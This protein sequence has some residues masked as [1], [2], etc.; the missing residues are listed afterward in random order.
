MRTFIGVAVVAGALMMAQE[1]GAATISLVYQCPD[2]SPGYCVGSNANDSESLVNA[3]LAGEGLQPRPVEELAKFDS[4]DDG[5]EITGHGGWFTVTG[6]D[7]TSG[8]FSFLGDSVA[9]ATYL[10]THFA[11]KAGPG[12]LLYSIED[13]ALPLG[14]A[15]A[16]DVNWSTAGLIVGRGNTPGLS[17]LTFYGTSQPEVPV[18][19]P[20]SMMLLGAGLLGLAATLRRRR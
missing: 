8:K 20:A 2:S 5:W 7:A 13:G 11:V 1:A 6:P 9:G 14:V 19:E 16:L 4:K 12:F 15:S 17:H 18:P 10:L 3:I